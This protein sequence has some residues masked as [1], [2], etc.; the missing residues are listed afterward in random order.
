MAEL[1]MILGESGSGKSASLRNFEPGEVCVLNVAGK[2]LPFRNKFGKDIVDVGKA[3]GP[4][5]Y[6]LI[7]RAVRS[8]KYK[9]YVVDD[10]Q[11][12]L[13]FDAFERVDDKGYG[14]F[15]DMAKSFYDLL[16]DLN[17]ATIWEKQ[18]D[19][20]AV[21]TKKP[22]SDAI[23]YFLHHP[24]RDEDGMLKPKTQGKMLNEKLNVAGL[25][26]T[27]LLCEADGEGGHWFV[28]RSNGR[29]VTKTPMG[30]FEEERIPNDL[31]AVDKAIREY[32][33][34]EG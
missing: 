5:R 7:K 28:T 16:R 11:Y 24:E 9:A 34:M 32:Y 8:G 21:D 12:L 10:S 22:T 3:Y 27:V 33:E 13:A 30:M 26:T 15:T 6:E 18:A 23:V 20:T 29:S 19:G 14:K 31:K 1:V 2:R 17:T 4:H 25:F